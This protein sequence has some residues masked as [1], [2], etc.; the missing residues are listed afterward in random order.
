MD[1][2]VVDLNMLYALVMVGLVEING[3]DVVTVDESA[4]ENRTMMLQKELPTNDVSATPLATTWYS[5]SAI[6]QEI[7]S[8]RSTT[9]R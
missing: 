4:A 3:A 9:K 2:V 6:D 1:E 5:T 8:C 7:T